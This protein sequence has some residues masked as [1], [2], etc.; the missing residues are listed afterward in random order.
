MTSVRIDIHAHLWSD[1]YLSLLD[2]YGRP[3]TDVHRGLG[4]GATR[5]D[6]DGR[7]ALMD[8]AG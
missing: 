3:G 2:G 4:A 6:L 7:F 1:E 8:E 5:D